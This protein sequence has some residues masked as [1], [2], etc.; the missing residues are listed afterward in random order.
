MGEGQALSSFVSG[1]AGPALCTPITVSGVCVLVT[2][3]AGG[4]LLSIHGHLCV[5]VVVVRRVVVVGAHRYE[6]VW[7]GGCR[8]GVHCLWVVLAVFEFVGMGSL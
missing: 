6:A 8:V 1:G 3:V 5:L 4:G 7:C 2:I